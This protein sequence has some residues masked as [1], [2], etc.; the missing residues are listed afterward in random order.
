L[1]VKYPSENAS[2]VCTEDVLTNTGY[3]QFNQVADDV[4]NNVLSPE[5]SPLKTSIENTKF[6]KNSPALNVIVS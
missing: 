5:I 6:I 1:K 2:N 3:Y 4:S